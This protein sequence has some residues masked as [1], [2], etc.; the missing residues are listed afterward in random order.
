MQDCIVNEQGRYSKEAGENLE[1]LD[2]LDSGNE[3]ILKTLKNDILNVESFK[4]SYPYDW[5]TKKPIILRA[6][7]QWFINTESLKKEAF[8]SM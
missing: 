6:S 3:Y 2:V 5:R 8:V 1:G 7:E 4:H